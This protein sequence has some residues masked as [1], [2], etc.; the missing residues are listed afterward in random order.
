MAIVDIQWNTSRTP[1][2][3]EILSFITRGLFCMGVYVNGATDS[4]LYT[5]V[6]LF[7]GCPLRGLPCE[8]KHSYTIIGIYTIP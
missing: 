4:V 8:R 5:K 3:N 1:L 2:G 7:Q 6:S